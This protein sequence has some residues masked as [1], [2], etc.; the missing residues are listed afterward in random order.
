MLNPNELQPGTTLKNDEITEIFK[1]SPQ[2]G[3]RRSHQT[4]TLI[5]ITNHVESLYED[6]WIGDVLHYTGMGRT[7][8]QLLNTQ[9]KTLAESNSN[10][11]TVHLFEVF[12]DKE[13]LYQGIVQLVENPYQNKQ[14]DVNG[15]ERSV[16]IF[17]VQLTDPK[18]I[19]DMK[20]IIETSKK[21]ERKIKKKSLDELLQNAKASSQKNVGFRNTNTK[22]WIR[23]ASIVEL[24][25]KLA[26][27][28]CQLCNEPAPFKDQ[29]GEPYLETHHIE[30]LAN[31][32]ADTPEN[33]VALCPNCHKKMHVVN[34]DEDKKALIQRN[35][36]IYS[37][38]S[39]SI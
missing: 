11:I 21:N 6:K 4:N 3:M 17:P 35:L 30:W 23:S 12:K 18:A 27:G 39:E 33:T 16:W 9:N 20:I 31:G 32:G 24:A 28:I 34:S 37:N 8:D 29:Y 7:G 2:G 5:I 25:K 13:Y 15:N 22:Y 1:C 26:N 10:G 36:Q 38:L 19:V 14:L